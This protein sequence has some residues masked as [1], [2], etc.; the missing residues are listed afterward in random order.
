MIELAEDKRFVGLAPVPK[1][2]ALE[3]GR[4]ELVTRFFAY[5]DGLNDYKDRPAD[6]LF[7]YSKK[8]NE[9]FSIDAGLAALY[10]QTFHETMSFIDT[11][12][13]HGFTETKSS[14]TTPRTRFEAIAIGSQLALE[15]QPELALESAFPPVE[16]WLSSDEF[17]KVMGNDGANAI[18][19]LR[20]R[21]DFVYSKLVG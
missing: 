1:K 14:K 19:R 4:E 2:E 21:I 3:R 7:R 10:R 5:G 18:A 16:E 11:R 15:E 17:L 20:G 12:F 8:M 9:R 6:V 13:P